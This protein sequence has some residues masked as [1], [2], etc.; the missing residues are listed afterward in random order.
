MTGPRCFA[1]LTLVLL[2][3]MVLTRAWA[4]RSRG[5]QAMNFGRTDKT[6]FLIPPFALFYF[7]LVFARAFDLPQISTQV[8]FRSDAVSW[9]GVSLAATGLLLML[10]SLV[11]FGQSFR[12]GIDTDHPDKLITTG[13]FAYSRNPIYLAFALIVLGQFLIFPNWILLVY[14]GA[15]TWL[16]RRQ[17]SREE[18]F[19]K[20]HY[21]Q[22]YVDYCRQ[23]R[24][25][26]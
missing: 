4:M 10:W 22:E 25:Y 20:G 19:L 26:I 5:I 15:A 9:V 7:Y 12:V 24:R 11:S 17:V 23:V 3:G 8:F 14:V 21:G 1:A 13:V 6:D 16:F 2:V 18:E